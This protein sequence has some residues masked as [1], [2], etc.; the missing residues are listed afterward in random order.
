MKSSANPCIGI[1]MAAVVWLLP[2]RPAA[3]AVFAAAQTETRIARMQVDIWPEYD[4]P[5]VLVIYSGELEADVDVPR[6]FSFLIPRGAQIHMAGAIGE[7]GGHLHAQFET[8]PKGDALTQVSYTL[9]S[10]KFYMEFY[11]DPFTGGENKEF[12]YPLVSPFP[13]AALSV[14]VQQPL[15]A[16]AFRTSPSAVNVVQDEKGFSYHRLPFGKVAANEERSVAVSYVKEENKPSISKAGSGAPG[17]SKAMRNILIIGAVLLVGVIGYS[18]V[19]NSKSKRAAPQRAG[20]RRAANR[21][22]KAGQPVQPGEFKY[23]TECG[24]QMQR[25]DKFCPSCGT[26]A[27]ILS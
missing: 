7:N 27:A 8:L 21:R 20:A 1:C 14:L 25:G 5:R 22:P 17:G 2:M 26:K 11:Y 16:R 18:V 19:A 3:T 13:I 9:Q 12:R 10:K 15:Q 4:D 24:T 23:C 6:P